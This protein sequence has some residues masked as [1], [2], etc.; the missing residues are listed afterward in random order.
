MTVILK[1]VMTAILKIRTIETQY[2]DVV[3]LVDTLS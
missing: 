1:K 3:E 2:A